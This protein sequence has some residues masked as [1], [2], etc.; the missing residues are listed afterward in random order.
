MKAFILL[1]ALLLGTAHAAC[2]PKNA[3][4]VL[5]TDYPDVAIIYTWRDGANGCFIVGRKAWAPGLPTIKELSR[6]SAMA[7]Y[8]ADPNFMEAEAL[9]LLESMK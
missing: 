6:L 1:C 3:K 4:K 7:D 8:S 2:D 5:V 9:K